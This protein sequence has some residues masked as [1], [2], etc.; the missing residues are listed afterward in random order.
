MAYPYSTERWLL[1][2]D[3][4]VLCI[5]SFIC[6]PSLYP[7][8]FRRT[9]KLFFARSKVLSGIGSSNRLGEDHGLKKSRIERADFVSE[10]E[11]EWEGSP[12][13][14][15]MMGLHWKMRGFLLFFWCFFDT[16][17]WS[18]VRFPA[19]SVNVADVGTSAENKLP[20]SSFARV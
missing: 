1:S 5:F 7:L 2:R 11:F 8:W 17:L 13:T 6:L 9:L 19:A 18:C 10:S 14:E 15:R 20:V 3:I 12:A 16:R 4:P